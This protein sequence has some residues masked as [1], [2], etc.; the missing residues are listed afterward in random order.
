MERSTGST[1]SRIKPA[2][3]PTR[4]QPCN[5]T[6]YLYPFWDYEQSSA[7][8]QVQEH[9]TRGTEDPDDE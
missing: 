6:P 8:G 9:L 5:V 1:A 4:Q 3:P 2:P 7:L